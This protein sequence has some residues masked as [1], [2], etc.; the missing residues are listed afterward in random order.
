MLRLIYYC[1]ELHYAEYDYTECHYEECRYAEC[2]YAECHYAE[3]HQYNECRWAE[4]GGAIESTNKLVYLKIT[5]Y[6]VYNF[7]LVYHLFI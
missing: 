3:C 7:N 2:H 4:S 6:L 1:A 5:S